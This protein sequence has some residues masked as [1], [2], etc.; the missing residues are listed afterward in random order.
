MSQNK[1]AMHEFTSF[2]NPRAF[3]NYLQALA[4]VIRPKHFPTILAFILRFV[5]L[6]N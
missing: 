6:H 5:Q 1:R 4:S 3:I 2:Y